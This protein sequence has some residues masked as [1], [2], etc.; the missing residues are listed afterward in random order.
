MILQV[1]VRYRLQ[2]FPI[3]Y[4]SKID[5]LR[6]GLNFCGQW[7]I[8]EVEKEVMFPFPLKFQKLYIENLHCCYS[9]EER[10][11]NSN[12]LITYCKNAIVYTTGLRLTAVVGYSV[13]FIGKI[14]HVKCT[15]NDCDVNIVERLFQTEIVMH[16]TKWSNI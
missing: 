6:F 15:Q 3:F 11:W 7:H 8:H 10:H 4:Y 1:L 5:S 9:Q 13:G 16:E 2:I 12:F 14:A